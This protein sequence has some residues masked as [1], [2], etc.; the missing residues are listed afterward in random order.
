MYHYYQHFAGE[1]TK[2][3]TTVHKPKAPTISK[4]GA[5][6]IAL[7]PSLNPPQPAFSASA[8]LARLLRHDLWPRTAQ[9]HVLSCL[10]DEIS[11]LGRTRSLSRS[12]NAFSHGLPGFLL[13]FLVTSQSCSVSFAGPSSS[14]QPEC[15]GTWVSVLTPHLCSLLPPLGVTSGPR[16]SSTTNK[17]TIPKS[18]SLSQT[19]L[20]KSVTVFPTDV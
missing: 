2:T 7:H 14:P 12:Q 1:E 17:L 15:W 3:R 11:S 8:Q 6:S 5:G 16:V 13:L 4:W 18:V 9:S 10:T 20:P 19:H